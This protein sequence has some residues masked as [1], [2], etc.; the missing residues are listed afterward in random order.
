MQ[1]GWCLYVV[2]LMATY[3]MTEALPLP[4][5]AFLPLFM[6]P[7]TGV[8]GAKT[9]ATEYLSVSSFLLLPLLMTDEWSGART[10]TSSSWAP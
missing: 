6:Y 8:M 9:V 2:L 3:W 7:I 10:R 1:A 4:I 5:T